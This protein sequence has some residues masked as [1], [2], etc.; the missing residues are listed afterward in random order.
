LG[1]TD[2]PHP[3]L[4]AASDQQPFPDGTVTIVMEEIDG[5]SPAE[6]D[7]RA[8]LA[9][10][11][12]QAR[13]GPAAVDAL[14]ALHLLSPR[15]LELTDLG[16]PD[17]FIER[18]V[19]RWLEELATHTAALDGQ[20]PLPRAR[21]IAAWLSQHEPAQ[22]RTGLLHGDPHLGNM[23]YHRD[24]SAV[25]ALIDWEMATIGATLLDLGWLLATWPFATSPS[26]LLA[27]LT[28]LPDLSPPGAL[29]SQ[30]QA[31]I[32][33]PDGQVVWFTVLACF[34]LA[35]VLEGTHVRARLGAA[36]PA[37]GDAL[38]DAADALLRRGQAI[39]VDGID[40]IGTETA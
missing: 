14:L 9:D 32:P 33:A 5:A 24:G 2:V 11:Q 34:K 28:Q 16:R 3:Q 10:P 36:D 22:A 37:V 17:G 19:P 39:T 25:A 12:A 6:L 8:Y 40:G 35:I 1:A 15:E 23:L 18:Q 7:A 20:D 29:V 26:P 31:S 30:Y 38:H 13:L 4:V 27:H 21:S